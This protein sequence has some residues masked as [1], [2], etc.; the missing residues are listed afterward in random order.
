MPGSVSFSHSPFYSHLSCLW[1]LN[2]TPRSIITKTKLL[3]VGG[4]RGRM[5]ASG[6]GGRSGRSG[7]TGRR[8]GAWGN[9]LIVPCL[10]VGFCWQAG[11]A[12]LITCS[13]TICHVRT[14]FIVFYLFRFCFCLCLSSGKGTCGIW[15]L[16]HILW[17]PH[18][19]AAKGY[20]KKSV[21]VMIFR[22]KS[23]LCKW[24]CKKS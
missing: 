17:H 6:R 13:Q 16:W 8:E 22:Q 21:S 7:R 15:M 2:L 11:P 20:W 3:T 1:H 5:V 10:F 4:L 9:N 24:N 19:R 23:M 18:T 14:L 12:S